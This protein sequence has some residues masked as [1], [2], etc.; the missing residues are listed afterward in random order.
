[1]SLGACHSHLPSTHSLTPYLGEIAVKFEEDLATGRLESIRIQTQKLELRPA[2][3]EDIDAYDAIFGD[4]DN[5]ALYLDGGRTREQTM[6]RLN[7]YATRWLGRG[8][9]NDSPYPYSGFAIIY[10]DEVVGN[11]ALGDGDVIRG[12]PNWLCHQSSLSPS[13]NRQRIDNGHCEGSSPPAFSE[14][15]SRQSARK[16]CRR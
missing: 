5:M 4:T 11:I 10:K 16:K 9:Y 14:R 2:T 13:G 15:L 6:S 3:T 7:M 12:K 1:M 8:K